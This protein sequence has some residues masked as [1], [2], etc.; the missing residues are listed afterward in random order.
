MMPE[1]LSDL[2]LGE[3]VITRCW[4]ERLVLRAAIAFWCCHL[5]ACMAFEPQRPVGP[6]ASR[7]LFG[8]FEPFGVGLGQFSVASDPMA[9]FVFDWW[10]NHASDVA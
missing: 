8:P 10:V 1:F 7:M 2:G 9:A 3:Y 4:H 6:P 5:F